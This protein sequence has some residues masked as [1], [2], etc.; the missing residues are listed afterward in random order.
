LEGGGGDPSFN[1]NTPKTSSYT[2]G[3]RK[4]NRLV[5]GGGGSPTGDRKKGSTFRGFRC[6][7]NEEEG[8]TF[9]RSAP[10]KEE[11]KVHAWGRHVRIMPAHGG[12]A[13]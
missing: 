2:V 11:K 12:E 3:G 13:V 1:G 4:Q 9:Q 5:R 10:E 7:K 8:L 6:T